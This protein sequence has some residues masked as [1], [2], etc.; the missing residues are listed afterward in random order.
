MINGWKDVVYTYNEILLSLKKGGNS[1]TYYD[2]ISPWGCYAK[3]N[4][5]VTRRQ[6]LY[7][8]TYMK[9]LEQSNS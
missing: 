3:W 1:D 9:Y 8:F 2:M 4:K 6:T 7:D 5:P